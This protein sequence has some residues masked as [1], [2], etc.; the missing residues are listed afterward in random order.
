VISLKDA[1]RQ[2]HRNIQVLEEK[3]K[4]V[5]PKGYASKQIQSFYQSKIEVQT[6]TLSWLYSKMVVNDDL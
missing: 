2:V 5:N 1:V 3:L 4:G 6:I